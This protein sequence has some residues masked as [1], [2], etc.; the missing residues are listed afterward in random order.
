[1][2]E[3]KGGFVILNGHI[4]EKQKGRNGIP[5]KREMVEALLTY[6][7]VECVRTSVKRG[8]NY[9]DYLIDYCDI[10]V[11][12]ECHFSRRAVLGNVVELLPPYFVQVNQS[13]IVNVF[14]IIGRTGRL[15]FTK[16]RK[17]RIAKSRLAEVNRTLQYYFH[18]V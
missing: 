6:E 10:P 9:V 14:H 15:L 4:K 12:N 2:D 17:Y 13:E 16:K 8:K 18:H 1:M 7:S 11:K 3:K 5:D